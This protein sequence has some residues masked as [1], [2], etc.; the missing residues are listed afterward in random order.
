LRAFVALLLAEFHGN[1]FREFL[2]NAFF[3]RVGVKINFAAVWGGDETIVLVREKAGNPP[4]VAVFL[5]DFHLMVFLARGFP[6]A[7]VESFE[8]LH[9]KGKHIFPLAGH[10]KG[11]PGQ[12]SHQVDFEG[13]AAVV[14]GTDELYP[15]VKDRLVCMFLQSCQFRLDFFPPLRKNF[16]VPALDVH[17]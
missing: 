5:M 7:P 4:P 17:I 10:G 6:E 13:A 16:Q 15:G 14:A 2:E 9:N 11:V 12:G 1:T 3:Q 8:G